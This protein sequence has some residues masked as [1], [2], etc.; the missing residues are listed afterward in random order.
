[1][2]T[3]IKYLLSIIL[4][5]CSFGFLL[6]H[7]SESK[8]YS[9]D[10]SSTQLLIKSIELNPDFSESIKKDYYSKRDQNEVLPIILLTTN[11]CPGCLSFVSE[12]STMLVESEQI[13][14]PMLWFPGE[15][16]N[17]TKRFMAVSQL[18]L[19]YLL[20]DPFD[21]FDL[22]DP[23]QQELLFIDIEREEVFYHTTIPNFNTSVRHKEELIE[24]ILNHWQDLKQKDVK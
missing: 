7:L 13:E 2:S 5:L 14:K 24:T 15:D 10:D 21:N 6:S 23:I 12:L 16:E 11:A 18:D 4:L 9:I 20:S 3:T 1:M 19:P 17:K 22:L 8:N